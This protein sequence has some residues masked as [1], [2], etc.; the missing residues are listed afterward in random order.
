MSEPVGVMPEN[1]A[2]PEMGFRDS[3]MQAVSVKESQPDLAQ[4]TYQSLGLDPTNVR[5]AGHQA[6]MNTLRPGDLVGWKGGQKGDGGYVGNI[7]VYAGDGHIVEQF[8]GKTRRRKINPS[9]NVFGMPVYT[10]ED[11]LAG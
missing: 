2:Q 7:A 6:N 9:E 4:S 11:G 8:F 10:G 1:N 5:L 3:L